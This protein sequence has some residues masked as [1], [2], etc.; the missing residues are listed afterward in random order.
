MKFILLF[1]SALFFVIS[2]NIVV[3]EPIS[4]KNLIGLIPFLISC[5][6]IDKVQLLK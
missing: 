1:V 2:L 3:S 6:I 5:Y 4:F